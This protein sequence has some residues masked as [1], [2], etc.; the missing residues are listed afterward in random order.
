MR[1]PRWADGLGSTIAFSNDSEGEVHEIVL[2]KL[3][4]DEERPVSELLALPQE[5]VGMVTGAPVGVSL[6][7]PGE[8]GMV[9]EGDLTVEDPGR[10]LMICAIP[11]G[12]DPQAYR[13]VLAAPTP[14][15][16]PPDVP[17]GP[18]HFTQGMVA[19]LTVQ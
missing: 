16:G 12:A 7:F 1:Y 15:D 18:P 11:T 10:Y 6:A 9:V 17:G 8:D 14:P 5:E 3:P 19:E 2:F 13:D 4:D